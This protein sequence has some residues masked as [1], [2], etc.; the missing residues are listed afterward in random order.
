MYICIPGFYLNI[1]LS[2]PWAAFINASILSF[3][4]RENDVSQRKRKDS[5]KFIPSGCLF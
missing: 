2:G 1:E 4:V 5:T 3:S